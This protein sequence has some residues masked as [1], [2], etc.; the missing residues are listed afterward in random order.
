MEFD[1]EGN[2]VKENEFYVVHPTVFYIEKNEETNRLFYRSLTFNAPRDLT[3]ELANLFLR[4][5]AKTQIDF[6]RQKAN[7]ME[8]ILTKQESKGR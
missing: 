6:L 5:D 7:W 4:V 1:K 2:P 8:K 3:Q